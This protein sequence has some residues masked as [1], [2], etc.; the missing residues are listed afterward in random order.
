MLTAYPNSASQSS[1]GYIGALASVLCDYPRSIAIRCCDPRQGVARDTRFLPT[2]A[3]IVAF[4]ERETAPLRGTVER[5][6]RY[7]KLAQAQL[8]ARVDAAKQAEQRMT[9]PNYD[10]LKA[11]HGENWGIPQETGKDREAKAP[12]RMLEANSRMLKRE[13]CGEQPREAAPGI[14]ISVALQKLLKT[15]RGDGGWKD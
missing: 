10:D 8:Q 11:K 15:P 7:E 9:Q 4:C 1:R 6:D 2:I 14:Q 3:D 12:E 13:Y 5:E